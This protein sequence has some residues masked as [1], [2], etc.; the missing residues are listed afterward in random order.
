VY[1]RIWYLFT[2]KTPLDV[3]VKRTDEPS[4]N[5]KRC[6]ISVRVAKPA[7]LNMNLA[8]KYKVKT[9]TVTGEIANNCDRH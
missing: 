1:V 9:S 7:T 5:V 6:L 4:S 8:V 2:I 3:S